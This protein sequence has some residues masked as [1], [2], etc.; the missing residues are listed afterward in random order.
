MT[1]SPRRQHLDRL[2]SGTS[3]T[4]PGAG[5]AILKRRDVAF[6]PLMAICVGAFALALSEGLRAPA[7]PWAPWADE[8]IVIASIGFG[9]VSAVGALL[10]DTAG[11][12]R[13]RGRF[14]IYLAWTAFLV[15][16]LSVTAAMDAGLASVSYTAVIIVTPYVGLVFPR[17]WSRISLAVIVASMPVIHLIRPD[18]DLI[19]VA[20]TMTLA[21]SGWFVGLIPRLGHYRASR[22]A[23]L[24]SRSDVL[25]G[26][27]NRRGFFEH[28]DWALDQ[29]RTAG[30]PVALLVVDLNGFKLINDAEGH[31][32]GDELLAWVGR[33]V[34]EFLPEGA[35]FGRLGGDEFAVFVADADAAEAVALGERLHGVL[36]ERVGSSFGIATCPAALAGTD[37]LLRDADLA[38][39]A[40]KADPA[41][42]VQQRE[43]LTD[44][45]HAQR[46]R[47]AKPVAVPPVSFERLRRRGVQ[48]LAAD[49][50]TFD[51]IWVLAGF[52]TIAVAGATFVAS[53][54]A[55][56]GDSFYQH[57]II[58][59][60]IPWVLANLAAGAYYSKRTHHM[61]EPNAGVVWFSALSV[62]LGVGTAALSTGDG[63]A[64]PIIA[65]LYL[66]VLFDATTFERRQAQQT[67]GA[68]FV[69]WAL[70]LVLGPS[71]SLWV[72]PFELALFG[73]AF[74]IGS[75]GH[76]AFTEATNARM[77]LANTDPLTG[78]LNRRGFVRRTERALAATTPRSGRLAVIAL[79]LDGFKQIN[80]T[81]GHAV[82]D[83]L[84]QAV[85]SVATDTLQG[86]EAIGRFGGDEF[87]AAIRVGSRDE[88]DEVVGLLDARLAVVT[89]GS[90]GG[91]L[92]GPDGDDLDGLLGVADARAYAVKQDRATQRGTGAEIA[93]E[94]SRRSGDR[95]RGTGA[96]PHA[97]DADGA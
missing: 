60:G 44:E 34:P 86:A 81:Q 90:V 75:I 88:L 24:L 21:V 83:R 9:V 3:A 36:A 40:A 13:R 45:R 25:T 22:Q 82:G 73:G 65:G 78:L 93:G 63:A 97:P 59:L 84:L 29:A 53:T 79:D 64:S 77:Q 89:A 47:G 48:A 61:G 32:A 17:K 10:Q 74:A 38:L 80:D 30:Q 85:S 57:L 58:Y 68:I 19:E 54:I 20:S 70:V 76:A 37:D 11:A 8:L 12:E 94:E 39:Y 51:G 1:S 71:G 67:A 14:T 91:A 66:K 4:E 23:L 46:P 52:T 41:Q 42:R 7:R 18:A 56:G 50:S 43:V 33:Q 55:G 26:A 72:A 6:V 87:V 95:G 35:A 16:S 92:Q 69:C 27:L 31:A 49:P 28:M 15:G 62:G 2:R 5:I 96:A